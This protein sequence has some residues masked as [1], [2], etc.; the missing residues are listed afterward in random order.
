MNDH[1]EAGIYAIA[2]VVALLV[3]GFHEPTCMALTP[4]K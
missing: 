4:K 2:G 3:N 1:L